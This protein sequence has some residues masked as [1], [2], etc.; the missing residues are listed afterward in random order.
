MRLLPAVGLL[1]ILLAGCGASAAHGAA[2]WNPQA[3]AT[4]LDRRADWWMSWPQAARDHGTFCVSCHTTLPYALARPFLRD[5]EMEAQPTERERR[6]VHNVRARVRLWSAAAPYYGAHGNT[7]LKAVE[8]RGTEAVLNALVLADADARTGR[9][10][11]DTRLAFEHMWALQQTAGPQAGAWPWLQFD[12][13]PWEGG[14]GEY[15]GAALAALAIACAPQAYASTPAIQIGAARLR[16][17]LDREFASQPLSNRALVLWASSR[18]PALLSAQQRAGAVADLQRAQK[19]DGGWSL[20]TIDR[21]STGVLRRVTAR[22]DG[23][24]TGL[25]VLALSVDGPPGDP[26]VARGLAWLRQH[27]DPADGSWPAHS[28]NT[29]H[30]SP[31]SEQFMSDAATAFAVLALA[32]AAPQVR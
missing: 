21:I 23:Y 24:A 31:D 30:P 8:S 20:E 32:R 16:A 9:L 11:D 13:D 19:Y 4:Y 12:L 26:H 3:A 1:A 28:L 6:I 2:S 15:F 18:M 17:Y 29:N 10:S 14:H 25:A 5:G 27:Q 7:P 22:S